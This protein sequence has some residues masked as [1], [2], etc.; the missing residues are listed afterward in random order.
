VN[1]APSRPRRAPVAARFDAEA[2]A[3]S[4]VLPPGP[5]ARRTKSRD[6]QEY[7]LL[8]GRPAGKPCA[9]LRG[10]V[11]PIGRRA[12]RDLPCQVHD[13][14]LW[15]SDAPVDL[16]RA[17][18]LCAECP[19]RHACLTGALERREPIGVW[20]GQIFDNGRIV[21]YKRPRGRPPKGSTAPQRYPT[22]PA[23]GLA[24]G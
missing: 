17:K 11:N 4:M 5:A 6:H 23:P 1:T 8:N 18:A 16:E 22:A 7:G 24:A 9:R 10:L 15:F 20:G 3:L 13:A 21:S 19:V 14:D 12:P 2:A